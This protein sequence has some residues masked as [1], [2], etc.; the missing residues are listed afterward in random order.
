[1]KP[2][3]FLCRATE[4][5][6]LTFAITAALGGAAHAGKLYTHSAL[7]LHGGPGDGFAVT[8]RVDTGTQIDVLWCNAGSSWCLVQHET[9]QG[10]APLNS[11]RSAGGGGNRSDSGGS[12]GDGRAVVRSA[13]V[14]DTS[15]SGRGDHSN[16]FSTSGHESAGHESS[17]Q[18]GSGQA[19]SG[20]A[21]DGGRGNSGGS[22]GNGRSGGDS[23]DSGS[24]GLGASVGLDGGGLGVSISTPAASVKLDLH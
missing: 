5:A 12:T 7:T 9:G 11:L 2:P 13:N 14:A 23:D 1:M 3:R 17:G 21:G 24:H 18:G 6:T 16:S 20:N 4:V 15:D 22:D 8:D 19:S 10:W